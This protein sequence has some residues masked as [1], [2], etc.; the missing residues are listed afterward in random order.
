MK[1]RRP[2]MDWVVNNDSYRLYNDEIVGTAGS[3]VACML[4]MSSSM[5]NVLVGLQSQDEDTW[6]AFPEADQGQ[7]VYAVRGEIE[8]GAR[9]EWSGNAAIFVAMRCVAQLQDPA[10]GSAIVPPNYGFVFPSTTN[11]AQFANER[12]LYQRTLLKDAQSFDNNIQ[13]VPINIKCRLRLQPMQALFFL[14]EIA[15]TSSDLSIR[16]RLRTLMRAS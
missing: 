8:F 7:T 4:T 5:R 15:G 6:T 13:I 10:D 3:N 11:P 9:F 14:F 16:P 1:R 12:Y 2:K